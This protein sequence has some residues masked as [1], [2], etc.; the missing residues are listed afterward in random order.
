M[1]G[2]EKGGAGKVRQKVESGVSLRQV[3]ALSKMLFQEAVS[4]LPNHFETD[5]WLNFCFELI[6]I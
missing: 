6:Q 4:Q 3:T 5:V 2:A 1:S